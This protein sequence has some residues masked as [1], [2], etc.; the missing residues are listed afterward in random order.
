MS[1]HRS[2]KP[3]T[4]WKDVGFTKGQLY[5]FANIDVRLLRTN[6]V[7]STVERFSL[8]PIRT[9]CRLLFDQRGVHQLEDQLKG[10][11]I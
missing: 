7:H 10:L 4:R 9:F 2:S 11:T 1:M 5:R 8:D 6:Y 3:I